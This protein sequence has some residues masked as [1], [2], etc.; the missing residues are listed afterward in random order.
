MYVVCK[1]FKGFKG[2]ASPCKSSSIYLLSRG[3][4]GHGEEEM[5]NLWVVG[6]PSVVGYML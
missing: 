4:S 6:S 1:L 5:C 3:I 2:S